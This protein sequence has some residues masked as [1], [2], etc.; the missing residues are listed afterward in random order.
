MKIAQISFFTPT[1]TN[2][3]A[4]SALPY[5]LIKFREPSDEIQVWTFNLNRCS[6]EQV[7]QTE[8]ELGIKVHLIPAPKRIN[9]LQNAAVRLFLSYPFQYYLALPVSVQ[10]EIKAFL[11]HNSTNGVWIYGEDLARQAALFPDYSCVVT[12]PDCEA[13]YYYRMLAEKKVPLS[14][15]ALARYGLMYHRYSR[16]ASEFPT[17]SRIKYHLVGKEDAFFL[18]RLNP[19]IDAT[20]IRHP[21]YDLADARRL[22]GKIHSTIESGRKLRLLIAGRY[23]IYMGDAVDEAIQAMLHVASEIRDYYHITFLGKNWEKCQ[24]ALQ[25]AGFSVESKGYVEDYISEVFSH[26]IQL[27]PISV[28][29]G[30]KGKVL[31]AFANGLMVMGTLRALENIAVESGVSCVQYESGKEL[32]NWLIQF[33]HEDGKQRVKSIANNGHLAVLNVHGRKQV[34]EQFYKLFKS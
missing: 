3:R 32:Q 20:F 19:C 25:G 6:E 7:R 2:F 21:H 5:H 22:F 15:K 11:G 17:G 30:T 33:T 16:M 1:A 18:Q 31:D 10:T 13:M 23:D 4:A 8:R 26:D 34:A 28:G 29:T 12:T 27:T 24:A 14:W 9:W